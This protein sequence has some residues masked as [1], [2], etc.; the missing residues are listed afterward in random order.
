MWGPYLSFLRSPTDTGL[1]E[2]LGKV[3]REFWDWLL[4][5]EDVS[6]LR[7]DCGGVIKLGLLH[8][9]CDKEPI[10]ENNKTT[11]IKVRFQC[12]AFV[13]LQKIYRDIGKDI[14][15]TRHK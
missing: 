12:P 7:G 5:K 15:H 11:T 13:M 8:S 1:I 2:I 4:A 3:E 6:K 14:I 9:E 10:K